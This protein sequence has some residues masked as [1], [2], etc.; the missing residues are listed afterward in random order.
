MSTIAT[1]ARVEATFGGRG[2]GEALAQAER[3][4]VSHVNFTIEEIVQLNACMSERAK[5]AK[6]EVGLGK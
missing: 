5:V 1:E 6:R 2:R 4:E 3:R